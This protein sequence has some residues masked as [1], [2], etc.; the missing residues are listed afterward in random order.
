MHFYSFWLCF[1]LL[2]NLGQ[3]ELVLEVSLRQEPNQAR[4][5]NP[6]GAHNKQQWCLLSLTRGFGFWFSL[7]T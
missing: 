7:C 1:S 3:E 2:Q 5:D 4:Q 6:P